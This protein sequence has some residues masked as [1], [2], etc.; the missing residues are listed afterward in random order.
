MPP[1]IKITKE[2]IIQTAVQLVREKG[3]QAVNA[4]AIA[5]ALG[6]S[7]Q[8]IFSNFS[9]MEVLQE[10]ITSAAYNIYSTFL[11]QEVQSGEYPQY[12]ALGMAYIRF[13]Q[14]EKELFRFLFLRD[15]SGC[16]LSPSPDFTASIQ[17]LIAANGVS[18]EVAER[19]HLEMW[20][21]VHGIGTMLA[22][23]FLSLDRSLISQMLTDIY[24]GIRASHLSEENKYVCN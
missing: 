5:A 18:A 20:A 22:T 16:D 10:A 23:N 14:E 17:I 3:A 4:R 11:T 15:R 6:C 19:M 9:T 24:Q 21:C 13:A 7:T 2:N 1:K 12:K 8:P